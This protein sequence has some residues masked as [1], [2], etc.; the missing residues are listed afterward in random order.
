MSPC[1]CE[2][3]PSPLTATV[4]FA[5]VRAT[6]SYSP[7]GRPNP[8][9]VL[10]SAPVVAS[11]LRVRRPGHA[12][13]GRSALPHVPAAAS[14]IHP[15]DGEEAVALTRRGDGR[16]V[17]A[18]RRRGE[19]RTGFPRRAAVRGPAQSATAAIAAPRRIDRDR[20]ERAGALTVHP[21]PSG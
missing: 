19:L 21:F 1:S 14:R 9:A 15:R 16:R 7:Y 3:S 13:V 17:G 6:M 10:H 18:A 4:L 12:A 8:V 11:D 5:E 20:N 2:G